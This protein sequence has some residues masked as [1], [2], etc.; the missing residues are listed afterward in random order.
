MNAGEFVSGKSSSEDEQSCVDKGH[1]ARM[2]FITRGA[3]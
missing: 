3:D 2:P 1:T